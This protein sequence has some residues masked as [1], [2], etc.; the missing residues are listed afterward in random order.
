MFENYDFFEK[1]SYFDC[2]CILEWVVYVRGVGVYGYFE[3]YGSF[4]D[5]LIL[6]YIWVKFFQEKGKKMLVFVCFLMVNYGKY[7]FE[8]L[9]D[10]CGFVVKF[11]IEDGNWDLVGNNL[12]IFFICDLLK[13]LDFVYVFQFDLVI[14]I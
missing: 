10:L 13:F 11:Y 3:V 1:I 8:I 12:K 9:R 2:E 6:K 4:G 14:N 7:L 5:E